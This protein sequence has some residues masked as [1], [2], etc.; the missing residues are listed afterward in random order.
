MAK[1]QRLFSGVAAFLVYAA[2][3]GLSSLPASSLPGGI[4]DFIPHFLEYALLAFFLAR[5]LAAP[6][7]AGVQAAA[8]LLVAV[9]AFLDERHQLSSPGRVFSWADIAYD[10]LGAMAGM[11]VA[12]ALEWKRRK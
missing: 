8:L 5:A 9:L 11:A 2:I 6:R 10:L 12:S 1:R 7:R 3:L 4:P